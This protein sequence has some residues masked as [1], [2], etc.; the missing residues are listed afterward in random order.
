LIDFED[1]SI[2]DEIG[3]E[4]EKKL[5]DR[6]VFVFVSDNSIDFFELKFFVFLDENG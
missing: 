4:S 5:F 1:L 6:T 2:L 3:N